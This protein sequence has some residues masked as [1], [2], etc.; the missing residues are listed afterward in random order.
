MYHKFEDLFPEQKLDNPK[1]LEIV[2]A[3][4]NYYP[5]NAVKFE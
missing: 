2:N 5:G 4:R 3:Q 1:L